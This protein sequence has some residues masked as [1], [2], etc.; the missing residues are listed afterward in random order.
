MDKIVVSDHFIIENENYAN[1]FPVDT[2]LEIVDKE[3]TEKEKNDLLILKKRY[4]V[5]LLDD[6]SKIISQES[7]RFYLTNIDF[8][9]F[10][11]LPNNTKRLLFDFSVASEKEFIKNKFLKLLF[12]RRMCEDISNQIGNFKI[13]DSFGEIVETNLFNLSQ[14]LMSSFDDVLSIYKEYELK[15]EKNPS[16]KLKIED[17]YENNFSYYAEKIEKLFVMS[18]MNGYDF[19][20]L[21]NDYMKIISKKLCMQSELRNYVFSGYIFENIND[22]FSII[23]NSID[24]DVLE[25]ASKEDYIF[26][27]MISQLVFENKFLKSEYISKLYEIST[28]KKFTKFDNTKLFELYLTYKESLN[29]KKINHYNN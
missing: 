25:F 15:I 1:T 16:L 28:F 23:L 4:I 11:L 22:F 14:Q 10:F 13:E 19:M 8:I 29:N 20:T 6:N 18:S 3:L 5:Y 26:V 9:H 24:E 12:Y 17:F 27:T 7:D 2:L 21:Y